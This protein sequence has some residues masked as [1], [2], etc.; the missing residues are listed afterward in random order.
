ML[1]VIDSKLY[2]YSMHVCG[3][4]KNKLLFN[5]KGFFPVSKTGHKSEMFRSRNVITN[6]VPSDLRR[7]TKQQGVATTSV[8]KQL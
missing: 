6:A 3:F 8:S 5:E 2:F 1:V 4:A 7:L